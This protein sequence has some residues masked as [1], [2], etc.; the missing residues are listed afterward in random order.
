MRECV[1]CTSCPL[2]LKM[3]KHAR[4]EKSRVEYQVSFF[5]KR[6]RSATGFVNSRRGIDGRL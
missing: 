3:L 2:A 6:L 5:S 1:E 4:V